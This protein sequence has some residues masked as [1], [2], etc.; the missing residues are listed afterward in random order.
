MNGHRKTLFPVFTSL[1][2]LGVALL[3]WKSFN[4]SEPSYQGKALFAW[5]EQYRSNHWGGDKEL[6]R[7]SEFAI[8]QIGS[9]G[10]PFLLDLIRTRDSPMKK[11]MRDIIP[12]NWHEQLHLADHSAEI[13]RV[14]GN[15]FF[16]LGTNAPSAVPALVEIAMHYPDPDSRYIAVF[17]LRSLGTAAESAL[18]FF[19]QCLTNQESTIRDEAAIALGNF[20][21]EA[22]F[23]VATL[24]KYLE[25]A[26]SLKGFEIRDA[27]S[28]LV[29]LG[30]NARAAMPTLIPLLKHS[31]PE[32]RSHLT[33]CL[34]AIDADAAAKAGVQRRH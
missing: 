14:G 15:G 30:T 22:E 31:D 25:G 12:R 16:A 17:A 32:V 29:R 5:V 27:A 2:V 8:R 10:I 34:V 33:N 3:V 1:F 9:N 23:A 13:R 26:E 28:S 4:R 24:T 11:K 7:Q 18:P 21:R 20:H 6:A 19:V